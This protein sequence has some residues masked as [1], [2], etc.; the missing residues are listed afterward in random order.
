MKNL[1]IILSFLSFFS[2]KKDHQKT[3]IPEEISIDKKWAGDILISDINFVKA[4]NASCKLNNPFFDR[5]E[6]QI[7]EDDQRCIL[8]KIKYDYS[9]LDSIKAKTFMGSVTPE[10]K[11]FIR[12]TKSSD[13][14]AD[15]SHQATLYIEKNNV[16]TDSLVIYESLNYSE[17]L[18]VTQ[19]YFYLHKDKIYLLDFFEDESGA[20]VKKWTEHTINTN[21]KITL[22]KE[23]TFQSKDHSDDQETSD[24]TDNSQKYSLVLSCGTG[25]AMTYNTKTITQ[26]GFR[27]KV[28]FSVDMYLNQVVTDTY[29]ESFVFSYNNSYQLE[30]IVR[31]GQENEDFL[32]TQSASSQQSFKDFA[33]HLVKNK[34]G[35]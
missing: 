16:P 20:E 21:G 26:D 6:Q 13:K 4:I 7:R 24:E 17:A 33:V 1:I 30:N 28:T 19:R 32:K 5:T 25:C 23:E 18:T 3:T 8:S 11:L 10:I 9:T 29:D 12:N 2:C 34:K 35:I 15:L 14:D 22:V 27:I 31:E